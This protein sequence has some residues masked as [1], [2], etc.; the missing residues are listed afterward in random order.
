MNRDNII[1]CIKN[2]PPHHTSLYIC[3][4]LHDYIRKVR[5][6]Y[7][8]KFYNCQRF[9]GGKLWVV[10]QIIEV[11]LISFIIK[12]HCGFQTLIILSIHH[13]NRRKLNNSTPQNYII[14]YL[15]CMEQKM[16]LFYRR[17]DCYQKKRQFCLD[18]TIC[19]KRKHSHLLRV[20]TG[21][22][23]LRMLIS[24]SKTFK[25]LILQMEAFFK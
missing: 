19:K 16:D 13:L 4:I 10:T 5:V 12:C 11:Q 21:T 15:P 22:C 3:P 23:I 14:C 20:Q 6:L 18:I 2:V 24:F 17:V 1:C 7:L 8:C 25:R 9:I